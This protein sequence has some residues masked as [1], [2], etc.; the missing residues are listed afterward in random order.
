METELAGMG[1]HRMSQDGGDCGLLR[2]QVNLCSFELIFSKVAGTP[3]LM[4][5]VW[6]AMKAEVKKAKYTEDE[7]P[8]DCGSRVPW[9][10][11]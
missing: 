6:S 9:E 3:V 10:W 7:A 11:I 4:A 8:Q 1:C 5:A 2:G